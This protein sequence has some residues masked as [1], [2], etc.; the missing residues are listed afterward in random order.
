M[1]WLVVATFMH[2]C[3]RGK[4][5]ILVSWSICQSNWAA[6]CIP[7]FLTKLKRFKGKELMTL[8]MRIN[9]RKRYFWRWFSKLPQL[10]YVSSREGIPYTNTNLKQAKLRACSYTPSM[11]TFPSWESPFLPPSHN[12]KTLVEHRFH[13]DFAWVFRVLPRSRIHPRC[14]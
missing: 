5:P 7:S 14:E 6:S 4:T 13:D 8:E 10:G 11:I 1:I 9:D 3:F 12:P 2:K